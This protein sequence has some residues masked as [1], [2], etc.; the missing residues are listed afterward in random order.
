MDGSRVATRS[1][2]ARYKLTLA[3]DGSALGGSQRQARRRSVQ[4]ELELAAGTLGWLGRSVILAGRTD[5]GT[6]ARG[7]VAALD[8][9]WRHGAAALRD[10][11]NANLPTDVVVLQASEAPAGF[12]PRFDARWRRYRYHVRCSDLRHP[13]DDRYAWRVWP[14]V[15]IKDLRR[16]ARLVVGTHD[17][18]AF[19][20]AARKGGGTQRTVRTSRWS[21]D[22]DR[23]RYDVMANGFLRR[24]VR[25]LVFVQVAFAQGRCE[26]SAVRQALESGFRAPGLPAG[27]APPAGLCLMEVLY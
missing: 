26:E 23:L 15:R 1:R 16:A 27:T 25:R 11:L 3:Y 14:V 17:F 10:A 19:G 4:S 5:A 13:L 20:A 2:M 21:T 9:E 12:H 18:G 6:H 22:E 7:Q 8:L 24:M